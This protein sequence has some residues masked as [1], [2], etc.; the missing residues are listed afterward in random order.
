MIGDSII[1]NLPRQTTHLK[2]ISYRG[3]TVQIIK[4]AI[5]TRELD[6]EIGNIPIVIL[7]VGTNDIDNSPEE[8]KEIANNLIT[9]AQILQSTYRNKTIAIA[10]IT[11]RLDNRQPLVIKVN[12]I[13]I[14]K[15]QKLNI[16]ICNIS[17]TLNK[18]KLDKP[19]EY[20]F[21]KPKYDPVHLSDFAL[22]KIQHSFTNF[23]H[24]TL[25]KK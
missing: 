25:N 6:N 18:N 24:E 22:K 21:R 2:T 11:P 14:K 5:Y 13:I 15:C 16:K 8:Y 17:K 12:D 9:T 7:Q 20:L 19:K 3:A 10:T 4:D 23:V 1:Q